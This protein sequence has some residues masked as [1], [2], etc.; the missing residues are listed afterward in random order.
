MPATHSKKKLGQRHVD[1]WLTSPFLL[2]TL[3]NRLGTEDINC[4][5][6]ASG[7]FGDT[8]L[9]LLTSP[10]SP[11][12]DS[13][14]HDAPYIFNRRQIWTVGRPVKHMHSMPTKPRCC[15]SCRMRPGIVLLK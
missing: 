1:H 5:S 6:F 9:E 11:L 4:Y 3:F 2:I 12:S 15:N 10:W 7:M 14:L 13:P 8:R